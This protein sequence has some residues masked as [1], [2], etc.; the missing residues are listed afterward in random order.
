M[1]R[2]SQMV[3]LNGEAPTVNVAQLEPDTIQPNTTPHLGPQNEPSP[4]HYMDLLDNHD[5]LRTQINNYG[6]ASAN[7][8]PSEEMFQLPQNNPQPEVTQAADRYV[9]QMYQFKF[10][11][12]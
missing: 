1:Y 10:C 5:Y 4:R 12:N 9:A 7:V 3:T 8:P 11:Y 6:G 2:E